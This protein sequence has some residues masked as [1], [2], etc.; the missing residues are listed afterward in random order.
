MV[1]KKGSRVLSDDT[2]DIARMKLQAVLLADSFT[3]K[4]HPITLE[5]PKVLLP[6]VN[7]PMIEYSLAWLESV[8][9]EEV[10]VFCCSHSQKVKEYLEK[11][12]WSKAPNFSVITIESHDSTSAGDA[13]RTIYNQGVIHGDFI[14]V[15]G[16]TVSNA[17]LRKALQEHKDRRKKDPNAVMTMLI[18][19]SKPSSLTHQ[20][21]IG[22]DEVFMA[23]EPKTKQ[24][25]Y[26]EDKANLSKGI[27]SLDHLLVSGSPLNLHNNR[28]DC[29]ID[30]CSQE[31]LSILIDNFDY[32]HIRRHFVKGLLVDDIM[33]YKI[34]THEI[35]SYAARVDNFR[36]Y[37]TISKDI[38]QRWTYP[39]VPN[40]HF[41]EN[42]PHSVLERQGI[43]K[44]LDVRQSHTAKVEAFTVVGKD[45]SIGH[46]TKISNSV[47]GQGCIIGHNVLIKGC[48][49]W[50][51]VTIED[52]CKLS[53]AIVCDEAHV[54]EG[55]VL[56]P[57]VI[58]SY[59]VVVGKQL[60]VPAYSIIS[61]CPQPSQLDSDEEL[62][63][64]DSNAVVIESPSKAE[65]EPDCSK[66]SI[67]GHGYIWSHTDG[68]VRE[69]FWRQSVAPIPLEKL[70]ELSCIMHAVESD[71][72]QDFDS[73]PV[74]G[75]LQ[76]D[77]ECIDCDD[78][79]ADYDLDNDFE[80]EVEATFLRAVNEVPGVNEDHVIL[81]VNSLKLS[82]N[83]S[84]ADCAGALFLAVM[85]LALL[86]NH[87]TNKEF[88]ASTN[89]VISR[90]KDLLKH[91]VKTVDD[92]IEVIMKF[93]EMCSESTK[94]FSPIFTSVLDRLYSEDIAS[95][96]A[97]LTWASEKEGAD[98]SDKVFVNQ[99]STFIQWLKEAPEEDEEDD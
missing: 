13:L 31:V 94:E 18:T 82:F 99:A 10:F 30:I 12:K 90:W 86:D 66:A 62:E 53:Y 45:T 8:E 29:Y 51:N 79:D 84:Y 69:E 14:L 72:N 83:V 40:V 52:N 80:K 15:S 78:G 25:L 5:R 35:S 73:L 58:L 22:T 44:E 75:E 85:K 24:L 77:S 34:F 76:H 48:Y 16:D 37:D 38:I 17:C 59:K 88:L 74:S 50:G 42:C 23:I 21:L 26:Y 70:E 87:S 6:L 33:E 41:S 60:V 7:V 67:F 55:A 28:Q 97:I 39:F 20:T 46:N 49:I 56:E 65:F 54:S 4:F 93:E 61:L 43:Y 91:Y 92:E 32:Q 81:E 68:G 96:D 57:G 36:S 3:M 27:L 19:H 71:L 63:Y 89:R 98:E 9:V 1:Q 2:D 64:V 95:E 11:S 47:I